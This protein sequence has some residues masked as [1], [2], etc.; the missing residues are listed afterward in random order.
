MVVIVGSG[1]GGG[2]LA[3]ELATSGIP[4]TILEKGPYDDSKNAFNYYDASDEGVDLLKTTCV[5]G[6]TIVS[7]ANAVRA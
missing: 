5:G 3:M 6:S 7:M 1:A 4:V 2:L